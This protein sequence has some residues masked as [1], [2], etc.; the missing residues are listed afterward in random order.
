MD[1]DSNWINIPALSCLSYKALWMVGVPNSQCLPFLL[2]GKFEPQDGLVTR[3]INSGESVTLSVTSYNNQ[4]TIPLWR[5]IRNGIVTDVTANGYSA[6][7]PSD[8]V[9]NGDVYAVTQSA[10]VISDNHFSMIRLIVRGKL[11]GKIIFFV[12]IDV[13]ALFR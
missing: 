5:R 7:L 3:T 2:T 9:M 8:D 10:A 6:T 12:M 1:R 13:S 11:S 4:G